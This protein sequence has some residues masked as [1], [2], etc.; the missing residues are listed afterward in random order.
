MDQVRPQETSFNA[1][2]TG[3]GG[4]HPG[5]AHGGCA[6]VLRRE[7]LCSHSHMGSR[8]PEEQGTMRVF[9][10][11]SLSQKHV[12]KAMTGLPPQLSAQP[13]WVWG[14]GRPLSLALYSLALCLT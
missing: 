7:V 3:Q 1:S 4:P 13:G 14:S 5:G 8:C 2:Q 9:A 11:S 10:K 6:V 12:S